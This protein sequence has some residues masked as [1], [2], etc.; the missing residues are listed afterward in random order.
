MRRLIAVAAVVLLAGS[1]LSAAPQGPLTVQ[2]QR[3]ASGSAVTPLA[4]A[5]EFGKLL[6][7]QG[8][9]GAKKR[10]ALDRFH[11]LPTDLQDR[12]LVALSPDFASLLGVRH[13]EFNRTGIDPSVFQIVQFTFTEIWPGDSIEVGE[14]G[15]AV[16]SAF[17]ADCVVVLNGIT[18]E[19][20]YLQWEEGLAGQT[21]AFKVHTGVTRGALNEF[22][23]RNKKTGQNTDRLTHL[24]EAPRG[25]RGTWGWKFPNFATP[26]IE[27][28]L[29]RDYFGAN[30]AEYGDGSPRPSAYVWYEATWKTAGSGG[31][32]YGMSVSSLRLKQGEHDHMFHQWYFDTPGLYRNRV[33]DYPWTSI[34]AE[35]V[36]QQQGAWYTNEVL[37]THNV[38]RWLESE[39]DAWN[40]V[41]ALAWTANPPVL[42]TW[43]PNWGHA[44][45]PYDTWVDGD[46]HHIRL[47]DNNTPYRIDEPL[48]HPSRAT[49]A[50]GANT[51]S[52]NGATESVCL[53]Y[54][55]CTPSNPTF[56]S[57][58]GDIPG[59]PGESLVAIALAEGTRVRQI[60][61]AAGHRFFTANGQINEDR[62]TAIPYS[63]PVWP[64]VQRLPIA[65]DRPVMVQRGAA[66]ETPI[67]PGAAP[68]MPTATTPPLI[69][70]SVERGRDLTL[71]FAGAG[72]KR[73]TVF[74]PGHA[75]DLTMAGEG[76][77]SLVG[78]VSNAAPQIRFDDVQGLRPTAARI[79]STRRTDDR[80]FDLRNVRGTAQGALR[81]IPQTNREGLRIEA[82]GGVQFDLSVE[83]LVGQAPQQA[84]FAALSVEPGG[85]ATLTPVNWRNLRG[86][87]LQLQVRSLQT[88][89]Q[90]RRI[91]L[92]Q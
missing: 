88:N 27:W 29:F 25:Y 40:R 2:P 49:V 35:T 11:A 59:S 18:C 7:A 69:V 92:Q 12:L 76:S 24:V 3:A 30:K 5:Q 52:Y 21:L 32:C 43:A 87:A 15:L 16:G 85:A 31:C 57:F 84:A 74:Q 55:E 42:V 33:W 78:L 48:P 53:S 47:W 63:S 8:I 37:D 10:S 51:F 26:E 9:T 4:R 64:L 23:V 54:E 22:W 1:A 38:R 60:T 73:C 13:V 39:R 75:F 91:N 41:E 45:V 90:L 61:D 72:E 71:E 77:L 81:L 56:P 67:P 65:V 68:V 66:D 6:N 17:N 80:V 36:R 28:H 20:E 44:V 79:I 89:E 70:F 62:A 46:D 19:T 34:L 58:F 50:W 83:G 14:W 82:P 86:S